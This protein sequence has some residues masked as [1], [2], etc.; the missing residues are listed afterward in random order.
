MTTSIPVVPLPPRN[1]T[2]ENGNFTPEF[3]NY[4]I[5]LTDSLNQ[6]IAYVNAQ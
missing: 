5:I 3:L 6:V 1:I 2:D 4:L